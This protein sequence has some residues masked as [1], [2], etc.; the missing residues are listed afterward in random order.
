MPQFMRE[1]GDRRIKPRG[2]GTQ[3]R[4]ASARDV[5]PHRRILTALENTFRVRK[6]AAA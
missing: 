1:R 3:V 5:R 4:I 6:L 2:A